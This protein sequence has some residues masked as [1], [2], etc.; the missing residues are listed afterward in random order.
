MHAY[1]PLEVGDEVVYVTVEN[2][3]SIQYREEHERPAKVLGFEKTVVD[4]NGGTDTETGAY[5]EPG[6][7]EH[8]SKV[9][10]SPGITVSPF[11][12]LIWVSRNQ[13]AQ[14]PRSRPPYRQIGERVG[15]VPKG[16]FYQGDT[17]RWLDDPF[18]KERRVWS[19]SFE[20]LPGDPLGIAPLYHLCEFEDVDQLYEDLRAGEVRKARE[21]FERGEKYIP[22]RTPTKDERPKPE[23]VTHDRLELVRRGSWYAIS[24][25]PE[26][27]SSQFTTPAEETAFWANH[28]YGHGRAKNMLPE[29]WQTYSAAAD[30][31]PAILR[32]YVQEHPEVDTAWVWHEKD[33][34]CNRQKI[35]LWRLSPA[36][37]AFKERARTACL[38]YLE[39]VE[40]GLQP[41]ELRRD[42]WLMAA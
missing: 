37:L 26:E 21:A 6:I 31:T 23:R 18:G 8:L 40:K 33:G 12:T 3:N 42:L 13:P 17:V 7:Y 41:V 36:F 4:V 29:A 5:I 19:R 38:A 16:L 2:A 14:V 24:E 25:H 20:P 15:D 22:L 27:L 1:V 35:G 11:R 30:V 9:V 32:R 28:G 34:I 10:I 39:A